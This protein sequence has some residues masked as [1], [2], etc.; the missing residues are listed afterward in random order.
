MHSPLE[1]A[2]V[3][4]KG[5]AVA[6]SL[7][8]T[9]DQPGAGASLAAQWPPEIMTE[10]APPRLPGKLVFIWADLSI[11]ADRLRTTGAFLPDSR[12]PLVSIVGRTSITVRLPVH[13]ARETYRLQTRDMRGRLRI[14]W[15][16]DGQPVGSGRTQ[17]VSFEVPGQDP[18]F[19]IRRLGVSVTDADGLTAT[20]EVRLRF[21]VEV[22]PGKQPP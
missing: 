10:V 18:T 20:R 2:L 6:E 22:P 21:V 15:S 9:P 4:W 11:T 14:A 17:Q 12:D 19:L 13:S 7:A 16:L 1:G 5:D 3:F 8:G